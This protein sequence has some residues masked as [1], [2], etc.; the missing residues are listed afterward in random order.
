MQEQAAL[1]SIS[2]SGC[3]LTDLSCLCKDQSFISSLLPVVEKDCSP[4]DLQSRCNPCTRQNCLTISKRLLRPP[5]VSATALAS[6]LQYP[7]RLLVLSRVRLLLQLKIPL[8]L[9]LQ[10]IFLA[11][12]LVLLLRERHFPS[13]LL[14]LCLI[15]ELL[16]PELHRT[17]RKQRNP[18]HPQL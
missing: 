11:R 12:S 7:P 1:S 5:R 10:V 3:K 15:T 4:A 14:G 16:P 2:S 9:P 6:L 13:S 18:P 8:Q 17:S